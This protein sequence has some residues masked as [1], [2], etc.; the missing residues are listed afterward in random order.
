MLISDKL[1]TTKFTESEEEIVRYFLE[2]K[3]GIAKK[4][5]REISKLLY[6]SPSSIVRLC[7]KIGYSGF[8]EFKQHYIEELKYL[9]THFIEVDP[10]SPFHENDN[11]QSIAHKMTKLYHE[12]IDDTLSLMSHDQLRKALN[13]LKR[14]HNIY[15]VTT[16]SHT[17][18]SH[19]FKDKMSR[20]GKHVSVFQNMDEAYYETCYLNPG[21][22]CFILIS[23]TGET[24]QCI[25]MAKKLNERKI[26]FITITSYG[27]NTLS[28]LSQNILYVST[29]EKIRDNLGA[30]S[31]SLSTLYLLDIIYSLYFS[32]DY[33]ENREKRI[34]IAKEYELLGALIVRDTS[35]DLI[36]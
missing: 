30:Y 36:K 34:E 17:N 18:I 13:I 1:K 26:E 32:L 35:N 23:Y 14:S 6:C 19:T 2:Q 7:Q 10:N 22:V 15:I 21:E 33:H 31:M 20:I 5:T 8:E 25:K 9:N 11:I 24:R 12:I 28:S 3:D 16:S 27:T 4:S 29:R